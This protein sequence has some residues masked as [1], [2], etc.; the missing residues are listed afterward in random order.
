MT[1]SAIKILQAEHKLMT[2]VM[3]E[4][5]EKDAKRNWDIFYK[6]NKTNFYK[7]RH[8]IKFEFD[9]LA[10]HISKLKAANKDVKLRLLDVGCGVGNGFYPLYREFQ[11]R[12]LINCC[13]FSPRAIGYVKANEFYNAEE[14]DAQVCDLVNDEIPF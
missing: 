8:Y 7:D 3:Y 2:P 1:D 4:K 5:L 14:V 9:E 6:N 12:L 13:D 10:E 11:S